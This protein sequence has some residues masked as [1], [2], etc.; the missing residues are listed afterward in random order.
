M[1]NSVSPPLR[2]RQVIVKVNMNRGYVVIVGYIKL[3]ELDV[4]VRDAV[5]REGLVHVEHDKLFP[6]VR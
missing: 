1:S 5:L 2:V 4:L 6:V 3:L